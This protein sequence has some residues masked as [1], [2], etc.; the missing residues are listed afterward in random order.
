MP[1]DATSRSCRLRWPE[2]PECGLWTFTIASDLPSGDH[3]SGEAGDPGGFEIGRLQLP[4]VRR[5]ALPPAD[6]ITH[7]CVGWICATT[8]KSSFV[9]SKESLYFSSPSF[10]ASSSDAAN[11]I[12]LPSGLQANC[13]TP[14]GDFVS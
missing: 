6:G 11:A 9:T 14:V 2:S 4:E 5:R 3:A 1:P 13:C 12:W 10:L 8:R 7:A